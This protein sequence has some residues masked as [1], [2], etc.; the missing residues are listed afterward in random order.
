MCVCVCVCARTGG[1]VT[2]LHE[3]L[4]AGTGLWGV[5]EG[6]GGQG[7]GEGQDAVCA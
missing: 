4:A 6:E 7:Q 3:D 2:L 1:V 5:S